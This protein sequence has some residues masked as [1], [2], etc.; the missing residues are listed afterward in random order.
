MRAE[1]STAGE[2]ANRQTR[3]FFAD[4]HYR[5]AW[6]AEV[7]DTGGGLEAAGGV[8]AERGGVGGVGD[9]EGVGK[10]VLGAFLDAVE[11]EEALDSPAAEGWG[12]ISGVEVAG[13]GAGVIEVIDFGDIEFVTGVEADAGGRLPAVYLDNGEDGG[14]AGLELVD[15]PGLVEALFGL[16]GEEEGEE[17]IGGGGEPVEGDLRLGI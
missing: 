2:V 17:G 15:A 13:G 9:G 1:K 11:V 10:A 6:E 12:D 5:T 8:A 4:E 16:D 3:S 7:V 14:S